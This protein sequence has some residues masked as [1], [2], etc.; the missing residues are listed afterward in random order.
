[1]KQQHVLKDFGCK[2]SFFH[3]AYMVMF[4]PICCTFIFYF[5]FSGAEDPGDGHDRGHQAIQRP[6]D[7]P[8]SPCQEEGQRMVLLCGLQAAELCD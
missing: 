1:M 8:C 2:T 4:F 3:Y 5:Y 7:G 6:L